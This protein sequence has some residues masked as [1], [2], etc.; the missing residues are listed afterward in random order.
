MVGETKTKNSVEIGANQTPVGLWCRPKIIKTER[1]KN[2][3]VAKY[4]EE[5]EIQNLC[6]MPS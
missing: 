4:E 2:Y 6:N 1:K 3:M 5:E